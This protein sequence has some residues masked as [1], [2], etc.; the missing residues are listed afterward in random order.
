VAER[1]SSL[2]LNLFGRYGFLKG[3]P[4]EK[5]YRDAKVRQIDEGTSN[6]Q[7]TTIAR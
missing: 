5:V 2:A 1:V 7:S 4:V 3:Y 6:L